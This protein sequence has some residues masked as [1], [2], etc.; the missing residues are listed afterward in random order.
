[1][2]LQIGQTLRQSG[3]LLVSRTGA[4][5]LGCYLLFNAANVVV[6]NTIIAAAYRRTG[7][8][9]VAAAL[10]ATLDLPLSVAAAGYLILLLFGTYLSVVSV[11]TFVAGSRKSFP[12]EALTRNISLAILNVLVG[13]FVYGLAVIFGLVLLVIPGLIA[14]VAFL[15]L[16]PY[17][18]VEDRNFVGALR[19]SYRLSKGNWIMLG[20][21]VL[22]IVAG[23]GL[24]GALVGLLAGLV[25]PAGLAQLSFVVVQAPITLYTVAVIAVAFTQLRDGDDDGSPAS[26]STAETPSTV[27]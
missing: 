19:E 7:L 8:R 9:E 6:T 21:L 23:A 27:A 11:R 1:M 25:V 15:F 10:P 17:I 14:Y 12:A 16:L 5:L 26:P 13:G 18:A 4:I 2:S 3:S 22:I 24:S 20:V